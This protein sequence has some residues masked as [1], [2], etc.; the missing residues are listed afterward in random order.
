[1]ADNGYIRSDASTPITV[2]VCKVVDPAPP[3][4][5][6]T[7]PTNDIDRIP[8]KVM[9]FTWPKVTEWGSPCK[10]AGDKKY[11]V[12]FW[13]G[14]SSPTYVTVNHVENDTQ[15]C[16]F[17]L[18]G[19]GEW[20]WT[21]S[22]VYGE[23]TSVPSDEQT[24]SSCAPTQIGEVVISEFTHNSDKSVDGKITW[25]SPDGMDDLQCGKNA[26]YT[27]SV[28]ARTTSSNEWQS[29]ASNMASDTTTADIKFSDDKV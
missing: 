28:L 11:K 5:T 9:K 1:M 23:L 7:H 8:G 24:F 2:K 4:G 3:S 13:Q 29:L 21:V 25:V 26:T 14:T 16:E 6:F 15:S 17:T 19:E 27:I 22:S 18:P 12:A 20:K 10:Y